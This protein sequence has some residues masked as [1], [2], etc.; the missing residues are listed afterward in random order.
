MRTD[1]GVLTG[2]PLVDR[3]GYQLVTRDGDSINSV[4]VP[5]LVD[6]SGGYP[7]VEQCL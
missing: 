4:R 6:L 2:P 3:G 7:Q 5:T 1:S